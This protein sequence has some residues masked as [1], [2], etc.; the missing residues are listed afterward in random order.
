MELTKE[1]SSEI[2]KKLEQKYKPGKG[3]LIEQAEQ[4]IKDKKCKIENWI[5]SDSNGNEILN[6]LSVGGEN[7]KTDNKKQKVMMKENV[8]H[9][10]VKYEQGKEYELKKEDFE[11]FTVKKFI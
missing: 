7:K 10:G 3:T 2:L 11:I 4:A 8:L 1:Q 5:L 9:D 6:L